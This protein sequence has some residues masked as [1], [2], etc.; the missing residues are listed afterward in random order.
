MPARQKGE[1]S[2]VA[3]ADVADEAAVAELIVE[4][5]KFLARQMVELR[6]ANA[7]HRTVEVHRIAH[8]IR[9]GALVIEAAALAT[10]AENLEK[11]TKSKTTPPVDHLIHDLGNE[12]ELLCRAAI[13]NPFGL[14]D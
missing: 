7:G 11:V 10:A 14:T 6:D 5:R 2:K 4:Y 13:R 9:G 12:V 8:L 3:A 1:P